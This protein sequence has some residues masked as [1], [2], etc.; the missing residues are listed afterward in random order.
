VGCSEERNMQVRTVGIMATLIL[1]LIAVS[2]PSDAQ[3]RGHIPVVVMLRPGDPSFDSNPK[4]AI[5]AFRQGLRE[6]GYVEG[7]TIRLE[8][9]YAE[10]QWDRLPSL[11]AELVQLKPDV[12][13]TTTTPGALASKQAITSITIV[14]AVSEDYGVSF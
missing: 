9:R 12:I 10:W 11:A 7:Q 6:L 3:P 4:S 5:N 13:V 1:V 14:V 8:H 2:S